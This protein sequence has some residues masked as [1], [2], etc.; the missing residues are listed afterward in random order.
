MLKEILAGLKTL[1]LGRGVTATG[2]RRRLVRLKCR[3]PVTCELER[4]AFRAVVVDMGVQG[5]RL[6]IPERLKRGQVVHVTYTGAQGH[7]AVDSVRCQVNWTRRNLHGHLEAGLSY[8][9]LESNLERSWVKVI[10]RELGF[11]A[12]SIFQR[13][14]ARRVVA[15]LNVLLRRPGRG[16]LNARVLNLGVGGALLQTL[17]P[18][19]RGQVLTMDL[20][21]VKG[22]SV[23]SVSAEVLTCRYEP[24]SQSWFCG[25]R[26]QGLADRQL[27]LLSR[28]LVHL[29]KDTVD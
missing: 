23:L 5:L 20:G 17:D 25:V 8:E 18:F 28:Y 12:V 13:R 21:P 11:D 4:S 7:F 19:E 27:D 9:D 1:T 6:E 2:E 3:Y 29:L 26:F 24:R 15:M 22:L 14:K 10:L 16:G